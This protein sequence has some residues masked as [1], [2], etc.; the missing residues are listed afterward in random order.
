[1]LIYAGIDEAGYGPIFGP[2]VVART[3]FT[4]D[5]FD[6]EAPLPCLW[7]LLRSVVC[8]RAGDCHDRIAVNDSKRLFSSTLGLG[9]LERGVLGFLG[10]SAAPITRLEELLT[11]LEVAGAADCLAHPCYSPTGL[12]TLPV[13]VDGHRLKRTRRRLLGAAERTG[14]RL[15]ETGAAMVVEDQFNRLLDACGNKALGAWS[16]VVG[17]LQAIWQ[18]YGEWQ[19]QVVIDRQGGR[20]YYLDLLARAFP[21]ARLCILLESPA[22]SRYQLSQGERSMQVT[23]Q[24]ESEQRHLPVALASMTAKYLRELMMLRFRDFWSRQAPEVRPTC[25]YYGDGRRFLRE[26]TPRLASLGLE[27]ELI[28]RRC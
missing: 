8:R 5:K 22:L 20:I 13:E 15:T 7:R 4:L 23:V 25:G 6:P 1:M 27:L 9:H 11:L 26:I 16:L 3:V 21:D 10:E 14:V 24:V 19:P 18:H 2:L 12:P 17:H 28:A